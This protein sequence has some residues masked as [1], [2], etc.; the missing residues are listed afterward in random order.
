M[1]DAPAHDPIG[2]LLA[3]QRHYYD[4]RAPDYM[5]VNRP[6]DRRVRG[7]LA[8]WQAER[9]V[10]RFGPAGDVLELACGSGAF[11]G[12]LVRHARTL[13]AV[14]G[15]AR[16]LELN[17]GVVAD[18]RVEYVC[19]DLFD[20]KPPRRFDAVFFGFWLSHVPPPRFESF[21]SMVAACLQPGARVGFVDEDDRGRVLEAHLT[22]GSVPTARRILGDGRQFDIV[23]VFWDPSELRGRLGELGWEATIERVGDHHLYGTAWLA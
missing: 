11:T 17:R 6:S 9:L 16:M 7:L 5:N 4:L 3:V 20:W 12:R 21:W 10:E 8:S 19:A 23:K 18:S 14:D 2:E 22:N 15:S 13:T 1:T